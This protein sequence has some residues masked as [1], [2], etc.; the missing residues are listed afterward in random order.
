MSHSSNFV[1]T[2]TV[3]STKNHFP[4]MENP[5]LRHELHVYIQ[6]MLQKMGC[7]SITVGGAADHIHILYVLSKTVSIADMIM[8]VKRATS[9]WIK[10]REHSLL[11]FAWQGSYAIFPVDLLKI[12]IVRNYIE[13]QVRH[14]LGISFQDEVRAFYKHYGLKLDEEHAWL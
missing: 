2:H 3:F 8:N 7:K 11:G 13:Q 4:F 10:K 14:H 5:L 1:F 9:L 6:A 12:D